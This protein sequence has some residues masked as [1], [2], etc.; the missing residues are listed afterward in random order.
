MLYYHL[1]LLF[2]TDTSLWFA[3]IFE[4]NNEA[5]FLNS[6]LQYVKKDES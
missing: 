4:R 3:K 1:N 5:F 6:I 2:G